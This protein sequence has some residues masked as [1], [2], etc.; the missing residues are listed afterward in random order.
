MKY[1][2][3]AIGYTS[4]LAAL[5]MIGCSSYSMQE[6]YISLE[7]GNPE[8][9]F[10]YMTE[11]GPKKSNLPFLFEHGLVAHYANRFP[12]SNVAL[13][14]AE[15]ISEDLYT[16]SVSKEAL[17]MLTND[18][19]RPYAGTRYERLLSH[20]YRVLNYI[21]LNQLDGALVECRRA[22]NLINAY[23]AEDEDYDFFAAGFLA[24]LSGMCFEATGEWND[25]F[26]S[27]R[28]AETYYQHAA[29][30]TKM[31]MPEDIG[32]ALVRLARKLGFIE[33]AAHYRNRYGEPPIQ[34]ERSGELILFYESGYVP[35]KY[36][37]TLTFPILKI[38]TENDAFR[39]GNQH[40]EKA[41]R[42][43]VD[44]LL[45]RQGKNYANA[46]LEYLLH[47]AMPAIS[48]KRP[49]LA[50][51][52]V[53]VGTTEQHGIPVADIQTMAI[54]ALNAQHAT[55]L[56][57]SMTRAVL[58]YL[59]YRVAKAAAEKKAEE[60]KKRDEEKKELTDE[61]KKKLATA[62]LWSDILGTGINIVNIATEKA[63]TRSWE[64]LPNQIFLVR[65]PLPEGV[66]NVNLSFLNAD[67]QNSGTRTLQNVEI[68]PNRITFLNHRTYK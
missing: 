30:K 55:I 28:Q 17:A 57:R 56:I 53:R 45:S 38:D 11:K 52:T 66:H 47:V 4:L 13:S 19:A 54:E 24:Y 22:T 25:A 46:D 7:A 9:A 41:A 68:Y 2:N 35:S 16:R 48:S 50:G 39:K 14:F 40:N 34:P 29:A 3:I 27:Y 5:F 23:K 67:G 31:K 64:T 58:K 37:K 44:T 26:I 63:D 51:V 36:E 60:E 10:T 61:E 20:Y 65:M 59:V 18:L 8:K 33:E 1:A 15:D 21:Y 32:H 12:E 62:Q 6:V 49:H 43:Y 42:N